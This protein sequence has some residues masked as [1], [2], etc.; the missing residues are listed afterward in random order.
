MRC[1]LFC[2]DNHDLLENSL[3]AALG[4]KRRIWLSSPPLK[5][6]ARHHRRCLHPCHH[7]PHHFHHLLRWSFG[8]YLLS[9][10]FGCL[11]YLHVQTS[12]SLGC[13]FDQS[14]WKLCWTENVL[15]IWAHLQPE[16]KEQTS[17]A[18]SRWEAVRLGIFAVSST[19]QTIP[20]W[21]LGSSPDWLTDWLRLKKFRRVLCCLTWPAEHE[22][23]FK[24][25]LS[26][27]S[28]LESWSIA[29]NRWKFRRWGTGAT[30]RNL[31]FYCLKLSAICHLKLLAK[32]G[33][34]SLCISLWQLLHA[35]YSICCIGFHI[36]LPRGS[37]L[38]CCLE[39]ICFGDL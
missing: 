35:L 34:L 12:S 37:L 18:T 24:E 2:Q 17:L 33:F 11:C 1:S 5:V 31:L 16:W 15:G 3:V 36:Y 39:G 4:N 32:I 6:S 26:A 14:T 21:L 38:S 8:K 10:A 7:C 27:M 23:S 19:L 9:C 22:M 30:P 28:F 29:S 20:C 13:S 25:L